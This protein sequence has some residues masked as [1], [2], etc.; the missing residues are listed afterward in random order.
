[1][2]RAAVSGVRDDHP[3]QPVGDLIRFDVPTT[4]MAAA[5]ARGRRC[6]RRT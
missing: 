4:P 6:W 2:R 1:M 5:L 3:L